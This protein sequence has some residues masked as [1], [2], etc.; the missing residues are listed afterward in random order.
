MSVIKCWYIG[1]L[2]ESAVPVL[3]QE[4]NLRRL[5][6][7]DR[8]GGLVRR[9]LSYWAPH[10]VWP[11]FRGRLLGSAQ[12]ERVRMLAILDKVTVVDSSLENTSSTAEL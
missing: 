8:L 5:P 11:T 4:F 10:N 2:T 7:Y 6:V 1:G 9:I 3:D 12:F